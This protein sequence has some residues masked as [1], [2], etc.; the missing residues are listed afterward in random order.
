MPGAITD[1]PV[2]NGKGVAVAGCGVT[3]AVTGGLMVGVAIGDAVD[4]GGA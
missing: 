2:S 3:V 1:Q 4:W